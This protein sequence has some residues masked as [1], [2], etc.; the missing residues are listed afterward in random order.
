M[1]LRGHFHSRLIPLSTW[2]A[3]VTSMA[4][5]RA[6]VHIIRQ[7]LDIRSKLCFPVAQPEMAGYNSREA[8]GTTKGILN[9]TRL[10]SCAKIAKARH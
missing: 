8:E 2:E 7:L 4:G 6:G 1:W 3:A 5:V 10:R 9:S